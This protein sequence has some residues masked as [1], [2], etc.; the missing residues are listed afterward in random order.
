MQIKQ[1]KFKCHLQHNSNTLFVIIRT[2]EVKDGLTINK[3]KY[4]SY[5]SE[6]I[7][8]DKVPLHALGLVGS[9]KYGHRHLQGLAKRRSPVCVNAAGKARQRW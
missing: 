8:L 9:L 7:T 5:M 2:S 3:E 1:R 4:E 6:R